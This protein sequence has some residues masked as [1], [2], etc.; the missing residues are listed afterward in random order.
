MNKK[1]P[2]YIV[3]GAQWG[4]EG[5]GQIAAIVAARTGAG[6]VVRTG[7]INAGHTVYH[8]GKAY[9]MQLLPT[10]AFIPCKALI[11]GPGCYIHRETL[12]RELNW[13]H[14]ATGKDPRDRLVIDKNCTVHEPRHEQ[15]AKLSNR[16]H[17]MGSTGKGSSDAVIDRILARGDFSKVEPLLF[18]NEPWAGTWDLS[19]CIADVPSML[20]RILSQQP[21]VLEGTQGAHLD[22]FTGPYPFT[23][24]R[25]VSTAA[26][27]A[28]AGLAPTHDIRPILVARTFPIRVAGNSGPMTR[29]TTW[30]EIYGRIASVRMRHANRNSPDI[31]L[32]A[33][34]AYEMVL[35]ELIRKGNGPDKPINEWTP[36]ERYRFRS[37]ISEAP[38]QA[39]KAISPKSR[40]SLLQFMETTTVT[41]KVRRVSEWD[42]EIVQQAITLNGCTG[43]WV[44]FLN[45]LFPEVWGLIEA[46]EVLRVAG[47]WLAEQQDKLNVAILGV[48]TGPLPEHHIT[49]KV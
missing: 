8:R 41:L 39:L 38:T 26:W 2:V 44:T 11:L 17:E 34:A 22:M 14:E 49:L 9:K 32:T 18:R 7:S 28:Y 37:L 21:I 33:W 13:V 20:D 19:S 12:A 29:E 40:E 35:N 27:L 25:A 23:T 48:S 31:P 15:Q 1:Q 47:P 42:P 16:H 10:A 46:S 43:M 6:A 3:Q 30:A 4:S 36:E 24:N 45:Y 5:K